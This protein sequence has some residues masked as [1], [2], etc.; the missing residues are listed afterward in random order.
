VKEEGDEPAAT[1]TKKVRNFYN[2]GHGPGRGWV[3]GSSFASFV[4]IKKCQYKPLPSQL[5]PQ[6]EIEEDSDA[7]ILMEDD[8]S[9]DSPTATLVTP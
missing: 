7:T 6:Q 8:P 3:E 2:P 5:V 4:R 9:V 1:L